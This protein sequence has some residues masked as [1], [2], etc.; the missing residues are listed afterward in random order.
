VSR[1]GYR[2]EL[3]IILAEFVI[4]RIGALVAPLAVLL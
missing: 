2:P 1:L 4:Y 3:L